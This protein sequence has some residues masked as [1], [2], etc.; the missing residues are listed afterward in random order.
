EIRE[1]TPD[2]VL[3]ADGTS[4][5]SDLTVWT[6][7]VAAHRETADWGLPQGKN[8]RLLVD[9]DLR[10]RGSERIFAAGDLAL[11]Q[12]TPSPQLA[13]PAIQEGKHVAAQIVRLLKGEPAEA[14][15]YYDK[16]TM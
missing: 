6:A 8:G 2:S 10:V 11:D 15:S 13:Q 9:P 14:F 4:L 7:G 16:G 12:K 3:L 5:H 1:V